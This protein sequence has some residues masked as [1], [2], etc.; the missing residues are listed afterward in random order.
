MF[1]ALSQI[2]APLSLAIC[3]VASNVQQSFALDGGRLGPSGAGLFD[4][5]K[6]LLSTSD[7]ATLGHL[8][9]PDYNVRVKKSDSVTGPAYTGYIDIK[10]RHLFFYFFESRRNPNEDDLIF[11]TE[12]GP[13]CSSSIGVFMELGPCKVNDIHNVSRNPYSWNEKA[14]IFFVDQPVGVGFSYADHGEYDYFPKSTTEETAKDI[15][16]FVAIFFEHFSNFKGRPFHMA[17]M[18]YGGRFIPT[19]ASAVYDQNAQLLAAGMTPINLTS[20]II[21]NGCTDLKTMIPSYYNVAC[22]HKTV[23]PVLGISPCIGIK[24]ALPRCE[25]WL[26]EA[27]Y[28]VTDAISCRT[29]LSFC[30]SHIGMPFL[31]SDHNPYDVT[32]R[33]TPDELNDSLCYPITKKISSFLDRAGVRKTLGIDP[34][35]QSNFSACNDDVNRRFS[36]SLDHVFPAEYYLEALLERGIKVLIYVGDYDWV[37]NWVGNEHMTL[38]LDWFGK[39]AFVSEPLREWKIGDRAVGVTRGSGPLVFATIHGAGHMV[40]YD[41]G[42]EAL[43]LVERWL[44]VKEL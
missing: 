15:S 2:I 16:A 35:T 23:A 11:W 20:V 6:D 8:A 34:S 43:V 27:C 39:N 40:P 31:T 41:K 29:A 44:A 21:Q 3:S 1:S 37:C 38:N 18:S 42:E 12:G 4:P 17:G 14:N 36:A 19:F 30:W 28:D 5:V 7:Y 10:A 26:K 13:G 24:Q 9:F 33:C 25:K 22:Q 32:K